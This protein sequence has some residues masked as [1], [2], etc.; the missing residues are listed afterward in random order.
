MRCMSLFRANHYSIPD[1]LQNCAITIGNFDGV[2]YGHQSIVHKVCQ[3]ANRLGIPSLA[4]TFDPP[5]AQLLRPNYRPVMLTTFEQR[6][7]LLHTYGIDNVL[8]LET[9]RELLDFEAEVFFEQILVA[10]LKAKAIVE[11]TN[12]HFGKGRKGT[13]EILDE[14]CKREG[15]ETTFVA[16]QKLEGKVV[17]SSTIRELLVEGNVELANRMLGRSYSVVGQVE[18]GMARGRTI[19]F[20]TANLGNITVLCPG[21]GVY[22]GRCCVRDTVYPTAIHIGPNIS[23]GEEETKLECYLIGFQ[24]DLYGTRLEV[25]FLS[26]LRG[27]M[28]FDSIDALVAQMHAD[29]ARTEQLVLA[30]P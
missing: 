12:F 19:G 11:G 14:W 5:P 3:H 2:H 20:P 8:I 18:H 10:Q 30:L 25:D 26:K 27:T 16:D 9:R 22:A 1:K 28:K 6:A 13:P 4:I 29:V 15:I 24:G 7:E 23:F 21:H 17:S